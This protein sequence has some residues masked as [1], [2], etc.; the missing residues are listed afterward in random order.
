LHYKERREAHFFN[1]TF[2]LLR[3]IVTNLDERMSRFGN[4]GNYFEN[5]LHCSKCKCMH[6]QHVETQF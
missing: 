5:I 3:R 6:T 4:Q 1:L 2:V